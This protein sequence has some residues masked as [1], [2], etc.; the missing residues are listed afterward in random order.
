MELI[1][2]CCWA[3][4]VREDILILFQI[5]EE[6]HLIFQHFDVASRVFL[7]DSPYQIDALS[8]EVYFL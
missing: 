5:L 2:I 1:I 6:T 3:K 7:I 8:S 4:V